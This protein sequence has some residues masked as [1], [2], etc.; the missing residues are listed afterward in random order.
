MSKIL[1]TGAT[2]FIGSHIAEY[3]SE[4]GEEIK[5]LVRKNSNILF[6]RSLE[7][8]LV[9]GDILDKASLFN[10]L[11]N[12]D[13]LIHVAAFAKDWGQMDQFKKINIEGTLNVLKAAKELNVNKIIITGSISSYGEENSVV[14]KDESSSYNSHYPYFLDSVFPCKLNFYRDSKAQST[15]RSIEF[16]EQNKLNLI[17]I[18]PVWVFGERE[19]NTGFYEYLKTVK[20]GAPFLP[21][22]AKNKFHVIYARDLARAYYLAHKSNIKGVERFIVGNKQ[23]EF[24]QNI[25]SIY[26]KKVHLKKPKNISKFL[27]YPVAFLME[28]FATLFKV[29]TPPLLTRG[30][31]NMFYDSIEY[32]V[33]KAKKIL[34]FE[35]EYSLDQSIENTVNWY[36]NNG[37]L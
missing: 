22:S 4:K 3:F 11:K 30:R 34:H 21:G 27:I 24:Q 23:T 7:V 31:V 19:F 8:E 14:K 32:N 1:L 37:Y 35:T 13:T 25:Y 28:L 18:E 6:L 15:V 9:T 2:G 29:K 36:K 16:A 12:C 33:S 5:C 26:C 17:V 10:A 20:K